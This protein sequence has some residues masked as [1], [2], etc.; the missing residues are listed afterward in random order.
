MLHS[1]CWKYS[2]LRFPG[3]FVDYD[4]YSV[5]GHNMFLL[6]AIVLL[7]PILRVFGDKFP[8]FHYAATR[9]NSKMTYTLLTGIRFFEVANEKVVQ[10]EHDNFENDFW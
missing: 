4:V 10:F 8:Y 7:I 5:L 6:P 9:D 3:D 1:N 2:M